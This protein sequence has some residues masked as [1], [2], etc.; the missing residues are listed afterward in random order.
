M[1]DSNE[2]LQLPEN[3]NT[4]ATTSILYGRHPVADAIR[5]GQEIEKVYL[6]TGLR[7]EV[8]VEIRR[9][10]REHG[11]PLSFAPKEKLLHLAK[12]QNHQG[13]VAQ[14]ALVSYQKLDEV[15]PAIF[16][17]GEK[18]LLLLLDGITDVRNIGAIARSAEVCGAH[19]IVLPQKGSAILNAEAVKTSAGALL[20]IPVCRE[21]SLSGVLDFLAQN[22]IRVLASDLKASQKIFEVSFREPTAILIGAEDLG[23]QRALLQRVDDTFSIPQVGTTDSLNVSVA[24]GIMLYEAMKQRL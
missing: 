18:P 12:S 22:G 23:V 1:E 19:A 21:K 13:V 11:I 20:K 4:A 17:R 3:N 2:E 16:E 24:T 5:A 9:L 15:L 7:G 6:L 8:E 14:A 10:T